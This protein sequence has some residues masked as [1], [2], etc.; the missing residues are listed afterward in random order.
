MSNDKVKQVGTVEKREIAKII[1]GEFNTV[2]RNVT[3]EMNM[4]EGE[5]L[6]QAHRKFGIKYLDK[7]INSLKS[8][9]TMIENQKIKLGFDR[10]NN[11]FSKTWNNNTH[12]IDC[13]TKAGR[14]FYEKVSKTADVQSLEKQRGDRLKALWLTADRKEVK[15]LA[16]AKINVKMISH[17]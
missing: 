15:E 16:E 13:K 8:K 7:E 17:K 1:E 10:Y 2:I 3:Q 14:F 12:Q 5:I 6:E 9:I 11:A 4:T